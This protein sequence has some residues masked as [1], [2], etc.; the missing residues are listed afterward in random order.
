MKRWICIL[1]C[2]LLT[3]SGCAAKTGEYTPTLSLIHI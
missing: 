3:L 2:I 1:L